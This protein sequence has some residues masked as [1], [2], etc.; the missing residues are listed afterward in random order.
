MSNDACIVQYGPLRPESHPS[1][2]SDS[3]AILL[4]PAATVDDLRHAK[5]NS[6][7]QAGLD[8]G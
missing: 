3:Q 4:C 2:Q 7:D 8:K 1:A 6:R 5:T